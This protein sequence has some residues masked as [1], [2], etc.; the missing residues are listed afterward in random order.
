M[1]HKGQA[2]FER[3]QI[4]IDKAIDIGTQVIA[5]QKVV[6]PMLLLKLRRQGILVLQ[7]LGRLK[8]E[9][10]EKLSGN[11]RKVFSFA[12]K[13]FLDKWIMMI[14]LVKINFISTLF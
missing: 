12:G 2:Q 6:H 14:R 3:V 4:F 8:T 9:A 11:L 7:R 5:C 1:V 10:L 13:W